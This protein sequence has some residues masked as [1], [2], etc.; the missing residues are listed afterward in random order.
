MHFLDMGGRGQYLWPAYGLTF[1]VIVLNVIWARA[2]VRE[3]RED[4]RRR[5]LIDRGDR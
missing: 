4:A 3:A 1:A 2:I 5:L